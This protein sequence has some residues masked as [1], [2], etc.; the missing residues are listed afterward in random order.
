MVADNNFNILPTELLCSRKENTQRKEYDVSS[1]DYETETAQNVMMFWQV[2]C[3]GR[4]PNP[5]IP[6]PNSL[7]NKPIHYYVC[8]VIEEVTKCTANI[9]V[10]QLIDR[11]RAASATFIYQILEIHRGRY[12][13]WG[14]VFDETVIFMSGIHFSFKIYFWLEY[15]RFSSF[16]SNCRIYSEHIVPLC[17]WKWLKTWFIL[18]SMH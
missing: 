15:F 9:T 14:D 6:T 2:S 11:N 12:G 16:T 1:I 18:S 17:F 10:T 5:N 7:D 13:Y 8:G 3:A 4:S